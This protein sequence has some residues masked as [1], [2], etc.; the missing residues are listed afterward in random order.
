MSINFTVLGIPVGK[1][2]P[3]FSTVNGHAVAYTPKKTANYETL[4]KLSYQQQCGDCK[5]YEKDVPLVATIH[6]YFPI[7][8]SAS[9]KKREQMEA[10]K[11]RHTKKCDA[12]NIAKACLDA[13]NGIAFYDD[14]QVCELSISKFYGDTPK[15]EI[16]IDE[17]I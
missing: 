4:V 16:I 17:V 6:A 9:K 8:K 1:G 11:I 15:V 5:P 14:S 3:K 7:P 12:D 10:G 13:L 2:R